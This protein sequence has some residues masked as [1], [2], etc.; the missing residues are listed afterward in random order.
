MI[1]LFIS[2]KKR[3]FF[4]VAFIAIQAFSLNWGCSAKKDYRTL[5]FFF[6]DVDTT[7]E[8]NSTALTNNMTQKS[9][10]GN[11]DSSIVK[12][13]VYKHKVYNRKDCKKCHQFTSKG[14]LAKEEPEL[15]YQCHDDYTEKYPKI[16]GPVAAGFCS[17]CH[18]HHKSKYKYLL[19]MPIREICQH[20]HVAGDIEKNPAHLNT[21]AI[22]CVD[23]H[24]SHGGET[25]NMLKTG[26][27]N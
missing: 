9:S 27:T 24:N 1:I 2:N 3:I 26:R 25:I 17:T 7:S 13:K 19:K 14:K 21:S 12:T 23:C 10:K 8:T 15:C 4:I 18:E 5:S 6:D 16:H 11:E 22:A 20:C